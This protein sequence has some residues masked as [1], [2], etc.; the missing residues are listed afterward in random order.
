MVAMIGPGSGQSQWAAQFQAA[1]I[2]LRAGTGVANA[3]DIPLTTLTDTDPGATQ[4]F[5]QYMP[6]P[7]ASLVKYVASTLPFA[8]QAIAA[9]AII[10]QP[11][12]ISMRMDCPV[13]PG[14]SWSA[15]TAVMNS[16]V[17]ALKQHIN[18]GGL[19][20][21]VTPSLTY[22]ACILLDL[23]DISQ[24]E[25]KQPQ[26]RYQWD[27]YVPL[28]TLDQAQA[29]L[30]TLLGKLSN[31]SAPNPSVPTVGTALAASNATA[32]QF[33]Q[34]LVSNLGPAL[35]TAGL[36]TAQL[37]GVVGSSVPLAL[38]GNFSPTDLAA[39]M[40]S[41]YLPATRALGMSPGAALDLFSTNVGLALN[42]VG[43]SPTLLTNLFKSS[44]GSVQIPGVNVNQTTSTLQ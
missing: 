6:L 43:V 24:G 30:N 37:P 26:Y 11:T 1:P 18:L 42:Q 23:R 12:N 16:L 33:S 27:F 2:L 5:A 10:Q 3:G 32:P 41:T 17:Q 25:T 9:N 39:H 34:A 13:P 40:A 7:G 14:G 20:N 31:Q 8:N 22:I 4:P 36:G 19:F 44:L 28:I 15:K 21:V 29:V 35:S 38:S